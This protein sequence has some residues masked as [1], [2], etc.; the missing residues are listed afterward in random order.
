MESLPKIGLIEKTYHEAIFHFKYKAA[1]EIDANYGWH[2][3]DPHNNLL[4]SEIE[5]GNVDLIIYSSIDGKA[6]ALS[7]I[8]PR[9]VSF[10]D[11]FAP[12]VIAYGE[13]GRYSFL[14][15]AAKIYG[16]FACEDFDLVQTL[17]RYSAVGNQ[18][19][20]DT[21]EQVSALYR[22]A[23]KKGYVEKKSNEFTRRLFLA[24]SG[25]VEEQYAV[26][27]RYLCGVDVPTNLSEAH[28]WIYESAVNGYRNAQSE[29]GFLLLDKESDYWDES[30]AF[31]WLSK[32]AKQ[33]DMHACHNLGYCYFDGI[34]TEK[35]CDHAFYWFNQAAAQEISA[36]YYAIG[37]CYE[38]GLGAEENMSLA[39]L[40]YKR[41]MQMG[42]IPSE[43]KNA[44]ERIKCVHRYLALPHKEERSLEVSMVDG[45]SYFVMTPL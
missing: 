8:K 16:I 36:A 29:I 9:N 15:D 23:V 14:L 19:P 6:V 26:G 24:E 22:N 37:E 27:I 21:Y 20:E 44:G 28:K 34:G 7:Y 45:R 30:V 42:F 43:I 38:D 13:S 4:I 33:G 31:L 17:Y 32:A 5:S 3:R 39:L 25:D 2:G 1:N 12:L 18:I 10:D 11:G 40:W 35:N 41:A